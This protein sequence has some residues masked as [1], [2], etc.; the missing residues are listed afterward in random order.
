M[1]EQ[2]LR[3]IKNYFIQCVYAGT[4]AIQDGALVDFPYI[5]DGQYFKVSGSVFNDGVYQYPASLPKDEEFRGEVW[6]LA[7]PPGVVSLAEKASDWIS[8]NDDVLKSPYSSESFG[9]YSYTKMSGSGSNGGSSAATWKSVFA[10]DLK[11]WR[12]I[13]YEFVIRRYDYVRNAE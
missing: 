10:D 6:L 5:Q 1:L 9:G 7:V 4:F 3:E 12:K 2:V 8:Q 13:R 11:E